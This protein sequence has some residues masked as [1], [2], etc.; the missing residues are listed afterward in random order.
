MAK[1]VEIVPYKPAEL[2]PVFQ[3]LSELKP[4]DLAIRVISSTFIEKLQKYAKQH[5][6]NCVDCTKFIDSSGQYAVIKVETSRKQFNFDDDP[7]HAK[8]K[9]ASEKAAAK[10]KAYEDK[11]TPTHYLQSHYYKTAKPD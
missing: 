2:V 5:L 11:A 7:T 8:L 1:K 3:E 6:D 9:A 10:L 4:R